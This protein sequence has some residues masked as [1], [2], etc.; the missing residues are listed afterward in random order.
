LEAHEAF[1]VDWINKKEL[2]RSLDQLDSLSNDEKSEIGIEKLLNDNNANPNSIINQLLEFFGRQKVVNHFNDHISNGV[3]TLKNN[4][5]EWIML[6]HN[7]AGK[8]Y[9]NFKLRR[10]GPVPDAESLSQA[11]TQFNLEDTLSYAFLVVFTYENPGGFDRFKFQFRQIILNDLP[12]FSRYTDRI[13]FIPVSIGDMSSLDMEFNEFKKT[14]IEDEFEFVFKNQ[15]TPRGF[16]D[17]NDHFLERTFD[18][19]AIRFE[20]EIE[21]IKTEFWRF[22]FRFIQN[23]TFPPIAQERHENSNVVDIHICVGN[24]DISDDN[25]VNWKHPNYLTLTHYFVQPEQ[26]EFNGVYNYEGGVVSLIVDANS[27]ASMVEFS[28]KVNS[29]SVGSKIYNLSNFKHCRLAAWADFINFE[30]KTKIKII[31]AKKLDK[32]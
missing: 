13:K 17:R 30:L 11:I 31:H 16:P 12:E 6:D 3:T 22:G 10:T 9:F 27:D 25:T 29:Q 8:L 28:I 23:E 32:A 24:P 18:I 5:T 20:I 21:P 4:S 14:Y 7:N 19:T 15:S 2:L 1:Y 26:P